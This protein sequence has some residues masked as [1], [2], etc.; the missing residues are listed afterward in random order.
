M[1]SLNGLRHVAASDVGRPVQS[2][3]AIADLDT[4]GWVARLNAG[5]GIDSGDLE[6]L[7]VYEPRLGSLADR[8]LITSPSFDTAELTP[9]GTAAFEAWSEA[10]NTEE[11]N[12]GRDLLHPM[13]TSAWRRN[14]F[15]EA[16]LGKAVEATYPTDR[17]TELRG[18]SDRAA[19][20][21]PRPGGPGASST[22]RPAI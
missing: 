3:Q 21:W 18:P 11:G 1:D 5:E 7:E 6:E 13:A 14:G 2:P 15:S 4:I 12:P 20:P 9:V 19:T 22:A 16:L 17:L 10:V 8:G